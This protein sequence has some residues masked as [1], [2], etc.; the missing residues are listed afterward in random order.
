M[1]QSLLAFHAITANTNPENIRKKNINLIKN[2]H[3]SIIFE[4]KNLKRGV[5]LFY[6]ATKWHNVYY[7]LI[8][9]REIE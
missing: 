4:L 2:L 7:D 6:T 1:S 3:N 8:V 5:L 9:S